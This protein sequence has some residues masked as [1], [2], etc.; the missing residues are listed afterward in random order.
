MDTCPACLARDRLARFRAAHP[1][2][3]RTYA[4]YGGTPEAKKKYAQSARG[5]EV[6]RVKAHRWYWENHDHVRA[7]QRARYAANPDAHIQRVINRIEHIKRA[8]PPWA[9]L[10]GIAAVYAEARRLTRETGIDHEVDHIVP[11]RGQLV[12][13]L[14]V[15]ANLRIVTMTVNRS[16]GNAFAPAVLL[17]AEP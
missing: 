7:A 15:P 16:K 6:A 4:G 13:G 1:D 3:L 12:S 5:M 9:D 11:L 14:H 17:T 2:R 8:T 10:D